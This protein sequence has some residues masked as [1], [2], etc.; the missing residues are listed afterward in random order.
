MFA[1][2]SGLLGRQVPFVPPVGSRPVGETPPS[3]NSDDEPFCRDCADEN[4]ICPSDGLPCNR[5]DQAEE[6]TAK[7]L[8]PLASQLESRAS[9]DATSARCG[10][11]VERILNGLDADRFHNL[12]EQAEADRLSIGRRYEELKRL[13][14]GDFGSASRQARH[15]FIAATLAGL[16]ARTGEPEALAQR[17]H[18]AY[19]RL[20][21]SF[22]YATREASAKPWVEVPENN[23]RLM[24]AVCAEILASLTTDRDALAARVAQL[25]RQQTQ[26]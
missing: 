8:A 16:A 11:V 26:D 25:E 18:E 20:A 4:G 24:T 22:G 19:E 17:F 12:G 5:Y 2:S 1:C 14:G 6:K 21:P 9:R 7:A 15:E 13:P 10:E 23:R 3:A